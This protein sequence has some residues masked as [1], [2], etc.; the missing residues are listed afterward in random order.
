MA[1]AACQA[2]EANLVLLHSGSRLFELAVALTLLTSELHTVKAE[3]LPR[4]KEL[5]G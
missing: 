5:R 3:L 2:S 1:I 4:A